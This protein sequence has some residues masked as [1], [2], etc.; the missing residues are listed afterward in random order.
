MD[1]K[2]SK[3]SILNSNVVSRFLNVKF[4]QK[5]INGRYLFER[6]FGR[7]LYH[8]SLAYSSMV[9]IKVR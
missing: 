6:F 5:I 8:T 2:V 1:T 3:T 4:I 7:E 9:L